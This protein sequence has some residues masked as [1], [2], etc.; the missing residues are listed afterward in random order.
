MTED[1]LARA[2]DKLSKQLSDLA[3]EYHASAVQRGVFEGSMTTHMKSV[4]V[5]LDSLGSQLRGHITN[6][7]EERRAKDKLNIDRIGIIVALVG[8][9]FSWLRGK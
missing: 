8:T 6:C 7:D 5:E 9:V 3:T 4:S 2:I 1:E